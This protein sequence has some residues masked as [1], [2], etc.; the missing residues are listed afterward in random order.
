MNFEK[1]ATIANAIDN[2]IVAKTYD[3][4]IRANSVLKSVLVETPA[5][6]LGDQ[7]DETRP[8]IQDFLD[9]PMGD[10]KELIMKKAFAAATVVA[11]SQGLLQELPQTGSSIAAL[12]DE[13]LTRVKTNYQVET[14]ILD[15][16]KAIGTIID[17]AEARA[18]AFID[19][20]FESGKISKFVTECAVKLTYAIPEIGPIVGPIAE[21][22]KPIIKG[23]VEKV[24]PYAQEAIKAGVHV[25][26]TTAKKVVHTAIEKAT[27]AIKTATEWLSTFFA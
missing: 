27:T 1:L 14:G 2:T 22:C 25:M 23:V 18:V 10:K 6:I 17:H 13:G 3:N 12:V 21:H 16:E 11:Q 24:K 15:P 5:A 8:S 7:T 26:A 4:T 9:S 20:A 19:K